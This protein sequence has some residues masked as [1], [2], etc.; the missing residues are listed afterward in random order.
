MIS[1]TRALV[2]SAGLP[3]QGPKLP[4]ERYFELMAVD[5]KSAQGQ[6]RFVLLEKIGAASIRG[7]VDPACVREALA[8]CAPR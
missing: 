1:P 8:R 3:T 6:I 2:S 5:K 4:A 7:G